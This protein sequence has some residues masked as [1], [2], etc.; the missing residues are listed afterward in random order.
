MSLQERYDIVISGGG[1][2]GMSLAIA[3]AQAGI[4]TAVIEKTTISAQLEPAFDGRVCAIALGSK[5]VL[6]NIGVWKG[7]QPHAE[8]IRDIRV[9]DGDTSCFLHYDHKDVAERTGGE[10]FGFIVENRYMRQALAARAHETQNLTLLENDYVQ[11]FSADEACVSLQTA[12]GKSLE[13]KLLI[14]ADGKNSAIRKMAGIKEVHWG[15]KQVAIVCT[16]AHEK[17]HN[18]VAQERFLPAGPFAALPM[19]DNRSSLVWVEPEDRVGIYLKLSED[20]FVQEIEERIG[21][22]LGKIRLEGRRFSYPLSLMHAKEYVSGR[23]V[24]IGDAAHAMHPL[25]GQGINLGFRDVAVLSE[26][27]INQH[28]AVGDLGAADILRHYQRWRRFDNV[29]MLAATDI[30]NRLFSNNIISL[31]LARGLGLWAVNQVRP[32]KR[33]FMSHAMGLVGDLPAMIKNPRNS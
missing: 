11:S 4:K 2:A 10:P 25:A 1:F 33:F 29:T 27:L 17:P 6:D 21:G 16:I 7:M 12:Q 13:V 8:P 23:V 3:L 20:E 19:T 28:K 24:L 22:Y 9:S 15:Y 5:Y 18:G 31:K 30:F 14:G 26:L 32:A